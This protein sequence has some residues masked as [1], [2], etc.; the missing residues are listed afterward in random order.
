MHF[1]HI[2]PNEIREI[3]RPTRAYPL[4]EHGENLASALRDLRA[5]HRQRF[6]RIVRAMGN[7]VPGVDDIAVR[8]TGG[9]LVTKL[10][11]AEATELGESTWFVTAQEAEGTLRLLGL[12]VALYQFPPPPFLGIE[13]PELNV[14]PGA[15]AKLADYVVESSRRSQI[16]LTTHSPELIDRL[17]NQSIRAVR[18]IRGLTS[19]GPVAK[20]QLQAV[21]QELFSLGEIH[22]TEGLEPEVE[23]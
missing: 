6:D 4:N 7:L 15:S 20:K 11:H 2:F 1:Y 21:R 18:A 23:D 22:Q 19:V 14:H 3:Q 16:L 10:R 9:Y 13:E 17:P 8:Q 12:L 5:S